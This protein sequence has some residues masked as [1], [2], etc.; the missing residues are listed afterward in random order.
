M[1]DERDNA[2]YQSKVD[3]AQFRVMKKKTKKIV[4]NS[5]KKVQDAQSAVHGYRE[6]ENDTKKKYES[7][8]S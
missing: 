6:R 2:L 3:R 1:Q 4:D 5:P 7:D 8:V